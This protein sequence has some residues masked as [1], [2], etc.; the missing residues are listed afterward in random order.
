MYA[1]EGSN[2]HAPILQSHTSPRVELQC[3][4][5]S[6]C[7]IRGILSRME[8]WKDG[9]STAVMSPSRKFLWLWYPRSNCLWRDINLE[10]NVPNTPTTD[11]SGLF[12]NSSIMRNDCHFVSN[13]A[14]LLSLLYYEISTFIS[15][16]WGVQCFMY[17]ENTETRHQEAL[18]GLLTTSRHYSFRTFPPLIHTLSLYY[19][20]YPCKSSKTFPFKRKLH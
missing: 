6:C 13:F 12:M 8:N 19:L 3:D 17:F 2:W 11:S 9:I 16:S 18:L 10:T 4:F 7:A 20:N 1:D 5:V 14:H 15:S